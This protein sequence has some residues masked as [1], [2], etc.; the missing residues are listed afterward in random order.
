MPDTPT[1]RFHIRRATASDAETILGFIRELAIYEREPDA[2]ET[3]VEVL[4]DQLNSESPPFECLLAVSDESPEPEALGFALFF[5]NYSTW[6]GAPGIHLED[7]FV[8]ERHRKQGIGGALLRAI[9]ALAVERGCARMEW[10]VLDWNQL[11]IDF[12][13]NIG[14]VALGEWTTMRLTGAALQAFGQRGGEA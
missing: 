12:Y 13:E 2:V 11:A 3:S 8:P 4:R 9:A 6:R 7:L 10:A 14:A 1:A 5:A